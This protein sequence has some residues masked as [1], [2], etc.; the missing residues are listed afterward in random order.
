MSIHNLLNMRGDAEISCDICVIGAGAAGIT[1]AREFLGH[2]VRM[3]LLESGDLEFRHRPQ[4]LYIGENRGIDNYPTTHSR[5]RVFGGSTTRWGGQCRPLRPLDFER[6]PEIPHSGWPFG[7]DHLKPFYRRAQEVCNLGPFDYVPGSWL[8]RQDN[9]LLF[10]STQLDTIIYQFSYPSDFGQVYYEDLASATNLDVYLNAN[11]TDIIT[12]HDAR[13]LSGVRATSF[14]NNRVHVTA[15]HYVLACGGI[16]NPRLLLNCNLAAPR[17]L[18]NDHDLV[19]R[20][21]MDHPYFMTGYF[22]PLNPRLDH[23]CYT[24]DDYRK[25][26][27]EQK[28]HA[29]F[30][31]KEDVLRDRGVN[32]AGLY[33]VRRPLYKTLAEYYTPAGKSFTHLVN[34]LR[35]DDLPNRNFG[36]HLRNVLRRLDTVA[37]TLGRQVLHQV[38]PRR[39][40]GLRAVLESTPNPDSRVTLTEKR[41]HFGMRRVRVD[42]RMNATDRSGF[43]CLIET[44]RNEFTRLDLGRLIEDES[45]DAGNWPNSM[46]GGKHHMGTTRMHADPKHGVVDGDCRVHSVANLYLAGSSVFPTGGFVNPTLTIIALAIRLADHL[47]TQLRDSQY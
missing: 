14:N 19:G 22:E 47:K 33:F 6:R 17:G 2:R 41:D 26:G 13:Q 7:Y 44:L 16:E 9:P 20:F 11:L 30:S 46:T 40:L 36:L 28:F 21:F 24:I 38:R 43:D 35:H 39:K 3:V 1:L 12:T 29:A 34:I 42:W 23:N 18:G 45:V 10:D 15:R 4:F 27:I 37:V 31:L 8:R 25:V 5:F 32:G